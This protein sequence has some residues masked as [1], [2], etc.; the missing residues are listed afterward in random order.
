MTLLD[1][2]RSIWAERELPPDELESVRLRLRRQEPHEVI[3]LYA[4]ERRQTA[5]R[6]NEATGSEWNP[7]AG[8]Q[9]KPP[10]WEPPDH[11]IDFAGR[12]AAIERMNRRIVTLQG[13]AGPSEIDENQIALLEARDLAAARETHEQA[14]V[15][16]TAAQEEATRLDGELS[17][18]LQEAEDATMDFIQATATLSPVPVHVCPHCGGGLSISFSPPRVEGWV[19]PDA[20]A[21]AAARATVNGNSDRQRDIDQREAVKRGEL[22]QAREAVGECAR[23]VNEAKAAIDELQEQIDT[24][25]TRQPSQIAQQEIESLR[26]S[27]E[28]S[29]RDTACYRR[30]VEA[31]GLHLRIVQCDAIE[32]AIHEAATGR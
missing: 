27:I 19:P 15:R 32:A 30:W 1:K 4:E 5:G 9:W 29:E 14:M 6:W 25:R 16:K 28:A 11:D 20:E 10:G 3:R 22:Q 24:L 8:P 23:E 26:H 12:Q 21:E 31:M 17:A 18:I 7:D 13:N 2:L